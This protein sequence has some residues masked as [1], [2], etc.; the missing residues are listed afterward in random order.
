[1][2]KVSLEF[3]ISQITGMFSA[4]DNNKRDTSLL[5]LADNFS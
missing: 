5:T 2:I 4:I 1:M 3:T